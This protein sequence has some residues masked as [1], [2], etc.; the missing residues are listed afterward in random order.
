MITDHLAIPP[1]WNEA[2]MANFFLL[3]AQG[4][5]GRF[6]SRPPAARDMFHTLYAMAGLG[7]V[8]GKEAGNPVFVLP[9]M[10]TLVQCMRANFLERP[11]T[12][13]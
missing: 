7:V 8:G 12:C 1:F 13:E 3:V 6:T 5:D 2:A 9:D 10:D 11:F 4:K